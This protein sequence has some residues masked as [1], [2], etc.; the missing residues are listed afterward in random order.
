MPSSQ[1]LAKPLA[2][3]INIY[4]NLVR[5][6]V[7]LATRRAVAR[8]IQR[9]ADRGVADPGR[10]T[11]HALCFLQREEGVRCSDGKFMNRLHVSRLRPVSDFTADCPRRISVSN[12]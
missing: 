2:R 8:H 1:N 5:H 10:L 12:L 11:V 9:L 4:S 6:G 3:A 7:D